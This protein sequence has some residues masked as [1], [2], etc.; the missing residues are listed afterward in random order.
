MAKD[1]WKLIPRTETKIKTDANDPEAMWWSENGGVKLKIYADDHE[2]SAAAYVPNWDKIATMAFSEQ[3]PTKRDAFLSTLRAHDREVY[4]HLPPGVRPPSFNDYV[5]DKYAGMTGR[6]TWNTYAK[7]E[8]GSAPVVGKSKIKRTAPLGD[9]RGLG[10]AIKE[11]GASSGLMPESMPAEGSQAYDRLARFLGSKATVA[12]NRLRDYE[13][14]ATGGVTDG[15][16]GEQ[17]G[18]LAS[19]PL[20]FVDVDAI[21]ENLAMMAG[22]AFAGKAAGAAAK[23]A[24]RASKVARFLTSTGAGRAAFGSAMGG[25]GAGGSE[26]VGTDDAWEVARAAA[27]GAA[28]SLPFELG[29]GA[30]AA[31]PKG[32]LRAAAAKLKLLEPDAAR[33]PFFRADAPAAPVMASPEALDVA[34]MRERANARLPLEHPDRI[35]EG[36]DITTAEA[37]QLLAALNGKSELDFQHMTES[38]KALL[39]RA[40][41]T[42]EFQKILGTRLTPEQM[43][44]PE[45]VLSAIRGWQA[46]AKAAVPAASPVETQAHRTLRQAIP[47]PENSEAFFSAGTP[48]E[49]AARLR[50]ANKAYR[51]LRAAGLAE[52]DP[53]FEGK[54]DADLVTEHA[55]AQADKAASQEDGDLIRQAFSE[56]AKRAGLVSAANTHLGVSHAAETALGAEGALKDKF[57]KLSPEQQRA[58]FQDPT[59]F[60]EAG[61]A[62]QKQLGVAFEP[63]AQ[64]A[65]SGDISP[66]EFS[67]LVKEIMG[68]DA[69][70]MQRTLNTQ[71]GQLD[72]AME[73][74]AES[75]APLRGE[76]AAAGPSAPAAEP[77]APA[78]AAEPVEVQTPSAPPE[79]QKPSFSSDTYDNA[80]PPERKALLEEW[81]LHSPEAAAD[82]GLSPG[83]LATLDHGLPNAKA[84][85]K[86]RLDALLTDM[87]NKPS[88]ELPPSFR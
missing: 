27:L 73:A 47:S 69:E 43:Q 86:K 32:K 48:K 85:A 34:G 37:D 8:D 51:E 12:G 36:S 21:P 22:G 20:G 15:V 19:V 5:H 38:Q 79:L 65:R 30:L 83:E 10:Q 82:V 11:Y 45:L 59:E 53:R 13:R 23:G 31:L 3:N 81:V 87:A 39:S 28:M 72:A 46:E 25:V 71:R 66:K 14:T 84:A 44:K 62:L 1:F 26:F 18:F 55:K 9:L 4:D 63:L 76:A 88:Q 42:P 35:P 54:T 61:A 75:G 74:G 50:A 80:P 24:G 2:P 17:A 7:G 40:A 64:A 68:A 29:Q 70:N 60:G 56:E 67:G 78:P 57:S 41:A 77:V 58:F 16:G 52:Q 49:Q 6:K 33:V